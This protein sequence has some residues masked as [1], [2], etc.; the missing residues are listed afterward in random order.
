VTYNARGFIVF[1]VAALVASGALYALES[2]DE[3]LWMMTAGPII[4]ILDLAYRRWAAVPLRDA[5]RG[6]SIL[7]LPAW[8]WGV[9]W[10][11]LGIY[12]WHAK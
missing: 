4:A 7:F 9:F 2:T 11:C 10:T 1:V 8:C 6:P 12:R 5:G 3:G